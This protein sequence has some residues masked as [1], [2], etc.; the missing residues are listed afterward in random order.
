MPPGN[1]MD[2]GSNITLRESG[3]T[4]SGSRA[5]GILENLLNG[6]KAN[7]YRVICMCTIRAN[8]TKQAAVRM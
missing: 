2:R 8:L 6:R 7:E 3:Q 1:R 4:S 5:T